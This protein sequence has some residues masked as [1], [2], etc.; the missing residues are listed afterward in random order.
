[1]KK[2]DE[3]LDNDGHFGK[4][5][6]YFADPTQ[7]ELPNIEEFLSE[8]GIGVGTGTVVETDANRIFF[9]RKMCIRDRL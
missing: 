3:Y 8:W 5:L 6:Y 2:I 7:P 1:M 9:D 4:N